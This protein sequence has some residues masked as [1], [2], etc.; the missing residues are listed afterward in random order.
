VEFKERTSYDP[1]SRNPLYAGA[2]RSQL[3]EL[4]SLAHHFHPSAALF[5]ANLTSGTPIKY[6][7]DPLTDFTLT[8]FLDRFVFR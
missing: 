6:T 8:K 1:Q 7:G 5:A 4:T 2:E 3:W